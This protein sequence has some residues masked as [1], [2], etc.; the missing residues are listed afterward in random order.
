MSVIERL[1]EIVYPLTQVNK[2]NEIVDVLNES[3]NSSYSSTNPALTPVEGVA[4][5]TVTHNLGTEDVSYALYYDDK[6]VIASVDIVS[7]NSIAVKFNTTS[8][9]AKDTYKIVVMAQGSVGSSGGG[10]E[11]TVDSAL[12]TTSTNPVQNRVITTALNDKVKGLKNLNSNFFSLEGDLEPDANNIVSFQSGKNLDKFIRINLG[13]MPYS[14]IVLKYNMK[15]TSNYSS[16]EKTFVGSGIDDSGSWSTDSWG[17]DYLPGVNG[18]SGFD[19]WYPNKI[20]TGSVP[21]SGVWFS[22]EISLNKSTGATN[23]DIRSVE[24]SDVY[25]SG[26]PGYTNTAINTQYDVYWAIGVTGSSYLGDYQ[27]GSQVDLKSISLTLDGVEH[28]MVETDPYVS[29]D[30]LVVPEDIVSTGIAQLEQAN[31]TTLGL[32]KL[33]NALSSTSEN[34]VQNKVI[35]GALN[36][37]LSADANNLSSTGQ[38]VFDGQWVNSLYR[39]LDSSTVFDNSSGQTESTNIDFSSY[40]PNDNYT[41]EVEIAFWLNPSTPT[42]VGEIKRCRMGYS[43]NFIGSTNEHCYGYL[44]AAEAYKFGSAASNVFAIPVIGNIKVIVGTARKIVL[45]VYN[46]SHGSF[47]DFAAVSYRRLGTNS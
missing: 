31:T 3:L 43:H 25:Y 8:T 27:P 36:N 11:I 4:T 1:P 44:G 23:F 15:W 40:L 2:V 24:G 41:Y 34:P 29:V 28:K 9:I 20:T 6:T 38:K 19:F 30:S 46:D 13:K 37:K 5:W 47:A 45:S 21:P 17:V 12:S 16:N 14:T 35:T 26:N 42:E 18:Y 32:V 7:E 33:D 10:G 39:I 22:V